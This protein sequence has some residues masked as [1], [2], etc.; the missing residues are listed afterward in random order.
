MIQDKWY[1]DEEIAGLIIQDFLKRQHKFLANIIF[2]EFQQ[3][4]ADYIGKFHQEYCA[5]AEFDINNYIKEPYRWRAYGLINNPIADI[6]HV[7]IKIGDKDDIYKRVLG[8]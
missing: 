2:E 8:K 4:S 5:I 7:T 1:E 3:K 6:V